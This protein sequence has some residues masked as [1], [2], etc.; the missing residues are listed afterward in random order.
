MQ[1]S[2]VYIQQSS[3]GTYTL[4]MG[5]YRGLFEKCEQFKV[6]HYQEIAH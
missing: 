6:L 4:N 1:N 2:F 3:P 5:S